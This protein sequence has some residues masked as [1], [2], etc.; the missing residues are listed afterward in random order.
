MRKR[1]YVAGLLLFVS[2]MVLM[3]P[4]MPHH[5]HAN[6]QICLK[7]DRTQQEDVCPR[8]DAHSCPHDGCHSHTCCHT[9]GCVA[10]HF[11]QSPPDVNPQ[12]LDPDFAWTVTLLYESV[13][14]LLIES[15]NRLPDPDSVYRESLHATFIVRVSGLRA[16]PCVLA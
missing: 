7:N 2:I 15:G 12:E 14:K 9:T 5:H 8:H 3:V 16:P 11:V 4:V 13:C 6:S 10:V 1:R